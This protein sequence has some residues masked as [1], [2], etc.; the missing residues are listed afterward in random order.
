MAAQSR[1]TRS[2]ERWGCRRSRRDQRLRP[3][4]RNVCTVAHGRAPVGAVGD[5]SWR[6]APPSFRCTWP[7]IG[8]EYDERRAGR[9]AQ[10]ATRWSNAELAGI[11]VGASR[12]G[13][14]FRRS[15]STGPAQRP[16]ASER[17]ALWRRVTEVAPR[18]GWLSPA[19]RPVRA[20][21]PPWHPPSLPADLDVTQLAYVVV[22][23][24]IDDVVGVLV[25]AWP[26]VSSRGHLS[27][28]GRPRQ[29]E[30]AVDVKELQPVLDSRRVVVHGSAQHRRVLRTRRVALGDVFASNVSRAQLD[31]H[32][33]GQVS[34]VRLTWLK[35]PIYDVTVDAREAARDVF[36]DAVSE[37]LSPALKDALVRALRT[38]DDRPRG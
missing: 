16:T 28:P 34:S 5:R 33:A 8:G 30:V 7:T 17:S 6:P 3:A 22:E 35:A 31:L 11:A 37:P 10:T 25:A 29:L 12:R 2:A 9:R 20:S 15:N 24:R 23:E 32:A 19:R 21:G 13:R 36:L 26:R 27:F 4:S 38:S 14:C 1:N 18:R